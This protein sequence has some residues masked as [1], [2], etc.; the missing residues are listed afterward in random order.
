MKRK[1]FSEGTGKTIA[2]IHYDKV[3]IVFN[4]NRMFSFTRHVTNITN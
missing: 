3:I 4:I 1:E 2:G